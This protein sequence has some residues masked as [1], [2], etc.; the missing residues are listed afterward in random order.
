[1]EYASKGS[2]FQ[3]ALDKWGHDAQMEM[4]VEECAEWTVAVKHYKR[5]RVGKEKLAEELADNA[6]MLEQMKDVVGRELFYAAFNAKL[7]RLAETL[8]ED[9]MHRKLTQQ[10]KHGLRLIDRS[11]VD[12]HGWSKCADGIYKAL[13]DLPA[14]LVEACGDDGTRKV[15]LTAPGKTIVDWT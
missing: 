2:V 1:V 8:R 11:P 7:E 4:S 9:N 10:E 6:I 3:Q 13:K 14:E 5:G 12:K 15:R